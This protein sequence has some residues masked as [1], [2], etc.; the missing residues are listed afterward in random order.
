[1]TTR[2]SLGC[3]EIVFIVWTHTTLYWVTPLSLP[4]SSSRTGVG[5]GRMFAAPLVTTI[6]IV[7]PPNPACRYRRARWNRSE[8]N[9]ARDDGNGRIRRL[10]PQRHR[11]VD[12]IDGRHP[13]S[14]FV[15]SLS[16]RKDLFRWFLDADLPPPFWTTKSCHI[17]RF[18][19]VLFPFRVE[20]PERL[21]CHVSFHVLYFLWFLLCITLVIIV[22][23]MVVVV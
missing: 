10:Y 20:N 16:L 15:S 19:F 14:T 3:L 5:G 6:G 1:M 22:V 21:S 17:A 11:F 13:S 4:A 9:A 12:L 2:R 8:R 7:H 23:V 18:C